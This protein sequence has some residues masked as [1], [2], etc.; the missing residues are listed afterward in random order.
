MFAQAGLPMPV[1]HRKGRRTTGRSAKVVGTFVIAAA[2]LLLLRLMFEWPQLLDE[3][4][5]D[6]HAMQRGSSR[7]TCLEQHRHGLPGW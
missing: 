3:G 6:V 7:A 2:C 1:R 4:K 5:G